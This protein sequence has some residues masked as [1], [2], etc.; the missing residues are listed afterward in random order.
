MSVFVAICSLY[1]RDEI[2]NERWVS[3]KWERFTKILVTVLVSSVLK[4]R[5]KNTHSR[6]RHFSSKAN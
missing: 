1:L 5:L 3:S 2:F 4:H 6:S